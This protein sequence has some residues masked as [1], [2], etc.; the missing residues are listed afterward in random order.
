MPEGPVWRH[1]CV[2]LCTIKSSKNRAA[3]TI[4]HVYPREVN[5]WA[6]AKIFSSRLRL[7]YY[8]KK[9]ELKNP[10][11]YVLCTVNLLACHSPILT[12]P[13]INHRLVILLR[14]KTFNLE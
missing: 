2:M 10:Q 9:K 6:R 5:K 8:L 13:R 1:V 12:N 4:I 7:L 11:L 3:S 14:N